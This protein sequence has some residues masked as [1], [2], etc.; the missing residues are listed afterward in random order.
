MF[1]SKTIKKSIFAINPVAISSN[2][3]TAGNVI[4]LVNFNSLTI[5]LFVGART[6]GT[7]TPLVQHSDNGTDFV[8]VADDFLIETETA[9]AISTANTI[10][11]IGYNGGKRYVKVSI[12]ATAITTGATAGAVAVLGHPTYAPVY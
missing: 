5:D 11:S 10:K 7:F 2:G 6:D 12:V 9:T 1:D 8:D 3:T 4:D